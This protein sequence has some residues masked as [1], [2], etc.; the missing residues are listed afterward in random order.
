MIRVGHAGLP[1]GLPAM[2]VRDGATVTILVSSALPP[3]LQRQA[4]RAVIRA[5]RRAGW[6]RRSVPAA[7]LVP[8]TGGALYAALRRCAGR[9]SLAH[10]L[11]AAGTLAAATALTAAV[12]VAPAP[13]V[14][15]PPA[16]APPARPAVPRP[17]RRSR[18]QPG[19][20]TPRRPAREVKVPAPPRRETPSPAASPSPGP[21]PSPSPGPGVSV[22]LG[23]SP[24]PGPATAS[25]VCVIV[26]GI[27]VC[28]GA[29]L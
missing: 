8:L 13:R 15:V 27:R 16:G 28:A 24:S 21:D 25:P 17:H 19:S 12:L 3:H 7:V 6:L 10:G 22:S 26:L 18:R 1:P 23:T 20:V 11:A 29:G 4:V 9:V 2:A 14:T 5:A